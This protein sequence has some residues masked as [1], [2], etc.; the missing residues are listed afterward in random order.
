MDYELLRYLII[1]LNDS[2]DFFDSNF[3]RQILI[4]IKNLFETEINYFG[5]FIDDKNFDEDK[6]FFIKKFLDFDGMRILEKIIYMQ[7]EDITYEV[8]IVMELIE[9]NEK[10]NK[11]RINYV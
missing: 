9:R 3:L 6:L 5:S 4:V 2:N 7:K 1:Y 11:E 8:K 10:L